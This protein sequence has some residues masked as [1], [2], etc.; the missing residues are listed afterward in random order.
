MIPKLR[1]ASGCK[2]RLD[3]AL[4]DNL[5]VVTDHVGQSLVN[6]VNVGAYN[7]SQRAIEADIRVR[8]ST[9]GNK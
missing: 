5:D 9:F 3:R 4:P 1:M 7:A 2:L 8:L 6:D